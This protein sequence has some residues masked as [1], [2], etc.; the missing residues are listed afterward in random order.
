MATCGIARHFPLS[1]SSDVSALI[2]L[3][4]LLISGCHYYKPP[5]ST[6]VCGSSPDLSR[7]APGPF[8]EMHRNAMKCLFV[9]KAAVLF[10]SISACP[11]S[12]TYFNCS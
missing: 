3:I 1:D 2:A 10:P 11:A 4:F 12:A 9:L 8:A 7:Q 6:A 5:L